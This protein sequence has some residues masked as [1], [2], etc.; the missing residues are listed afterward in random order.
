M[1]AEI[2]DA[3]KPF[4]LLACGGRDYQ[5]R[6]A[7]YNALNKI[8]AKHPNITILTGAATGADWIAQ[9]WALAHERPFIGVPA[10]WATYGKSAGPRRNTMLLHYLPN[11]VVA[12]PGGDGTAD[13]CRQAEAAG[14]SVW[15]PEGK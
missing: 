12:F 8:H 7:V 2:A 5:D 3:G 10:E 14:L 11:G 9:D 1:S 6:N 15:Y 13:M 4:L